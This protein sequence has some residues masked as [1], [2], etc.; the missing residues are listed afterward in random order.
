MVTPIVGANNVNAQVNL[1]IDFTR[2]EVSQEIVDPDTFATLSEQNSLNVTAKKDAVG[3]PGAISNEPPQE[4]TVNQQ[5]NQAGIASNENQS[6]EEQQ[7]ETKSSTE[8]KNYEVSKTFETVKNPSNLITRI[9]A[10]L[11]IRDRKVTDPDTGEQT[12]QPVSAEVIS[13][14]ENLV[15]SALEIKI[16][17]GRYFNNNV[18]TFC[19]RIRRICN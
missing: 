13:E 5:Q 1:E 6:G 15:K 9:D 4:A 16:R 2:K 7:F 14:L 12:F 19:R 18:A 3:I 11:L 17:S 8:L 10:A